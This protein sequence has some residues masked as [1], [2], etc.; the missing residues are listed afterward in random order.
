M[1]VQSAR[2][3]RRMA[4][5]NVLGYPTATNKNAVAL[6]RRCRGLYCVYVG[7]LHYSRAQRDG[8][9]DAAPVWQGRT[10]PRRDREGRSYG[11]TGDSRNLKSREHAVGT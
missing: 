2:W 3:R 8:H 9:E 10:Q 6:L 4:F 5:C 7:V 1:H 11:V